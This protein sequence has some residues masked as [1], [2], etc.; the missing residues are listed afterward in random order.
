MYLFWRSRTRSVQEHAT[1]AFK[2]L[3]NVECRTFHSLA[4]CVGGQYRH[5]SSWAVKTYDVSRWVEP[6]ER[7]PLERNKRGEP[8]KEDLFLFSKYV[9]QTLESFL[10]SDDQEIDLNHLP[11]CSSPDIR[12]PV[13][14]YQQAVSVVMEAEV[15]SEARKVWDRMK[16]RDDRKVGMTHD[17][18]LK[19]YQLQKPTL[20]YGCLLVDESQD[21]TPAIISILL[22][23]S[24]PKVMVGDPHQQIYSFK[25]ACNAFTSVLATRTYCL[26]ESFR[27]GP[28]IAYVASCLLDVLK[29]VRRSTIVGG[30]QP[31]GVEGVWEGQLAVIA[32][33]NAVLFDSMVDLCNQHDTYKF[34]FAGGIQG[35]EF[36][37]YQAIYDLMVGKK[38][39]HNFISKFSTYDDLCYYAQRADDP[40]LSGK[41]TVCERYNDTLPYYLEKIT[42]MKC[43]DTR[44]ADVVFSTAHKS[45]GLE[46][47]TVRLCDDFLNC[48][49]DE[50]IED[51]LPL[52]KISQD[53]LNLLYVAVTRAK[54]QLIMSP[55]LVRL[56]RR[57][58]ECFLY[59]TGVPTLRAE[60]NSCVRCKSPG[61]TGNLP[62]E[63]ASSIT[64]CDGSVMDSGL[65]CAC[66]THDCHV[67]VFSLL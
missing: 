20:N 62:I 25:G 19:L 47:D 67:D 18:Y 36:D 2:G 15:I 48:L 11:I 12:S 61:F 35:Y 49:N 23:Q 21:L 58:K 10:A 41:L 7:W 33:T 39:K 3:K 63:R 38:P 29:R 22:N 54:K 14:I 8:K 16:N 45:K 5:K 32:R 44:I 55:T 50:D 53:E 51:A 1:V 56:L 31:G 66:C 57:A 24:C 13:E 27:F 52:D 34:G 60:V 4:Y 64:L 17:G 30:L 65:V 37:T 46:F 26:S 59:P 28:E 9:L 43:T 42:G 6:P 40:A